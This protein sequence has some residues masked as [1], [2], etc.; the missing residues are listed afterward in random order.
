MQL[1]PDHWIVVLG[2]SEDVA[3][4]TSSLLMIDLVDQ[5]VL[6]PFSVICYAK[7]RQTV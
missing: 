3:L 2:V 1:D 7:T 4:L 6:G 5:Q